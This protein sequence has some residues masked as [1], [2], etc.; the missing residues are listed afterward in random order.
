MLNFE[1][2]IL[3]SILFVSI[4]VVN[5]AFAICLSDKDWPENPCFD[6]LP[7]SKSSLQ[8][9]MD[10]YYSMK[11]QEWM[12]MKKAEMDYAIEN[13]ILEYWISKGDESKGFANSNVYMYYFVYDE[14]PSLG[15]YYNRLIIEED[16]DPDMEFYPGDI[17]ENIPPA[18]AIN[19]YQGPI[20]WSLL[21]AGI[22]AIGFIFVKKL[23]RK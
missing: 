17:E 18:R 13:R 1:R 3:F 22:V 23:M 19:P 20:I 5:T 21:I 2:V 14:A 9:S 7:Y 11:G 10:Q 16:R 12:E 6:N 8:S 4:F 15:G